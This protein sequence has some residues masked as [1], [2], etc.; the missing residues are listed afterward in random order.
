M[1]IF[2]V[3]E[4]V[5]SSERGVLSSGTDLVWGGVLA[6]ERLCYSHSFHATTEGHQH[7]FDD[8]RKRIIL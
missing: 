4:V 5:G 6:V 1:G 8:T 2:L 7:L 3:G